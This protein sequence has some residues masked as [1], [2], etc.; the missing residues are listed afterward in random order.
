MNIAQVSQKV[1]ATTQKTAAVCTGSG[2]RSCWTRALAGA[3]LVT[4]AILLGRGKRAAGLSLAAAGTL[5]ALLEDP[6]VARDLWKGLPG[7]IEA[8]QG[9]LTRFEKFVEELGEQGNR[10]RVLLAKQAR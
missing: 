4:G 2:T 9:Y 3:S 10:I 6:K 5:V 7:Y 8:G 1:A